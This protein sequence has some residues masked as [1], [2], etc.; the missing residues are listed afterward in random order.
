LLVPYLK[1]N[2]ALGI[3]ALKYFKIQ[4]KIE[5]FYNSRL[6]GRLTL[7][8]KN[9]LVDVGHNVLAAESILESLKGKKYILVY[10]SYKDKNYK[11]ILSIL[12]PVI[13]HVEL[14]DVYNIRIAESNYLQNT[15]ETLE[16]EYN[17]FKK[18]D[19]KKNYLVFGSFSVVE[20]FLKVYRG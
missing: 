1:E 5:D 10:N 14:I 15:L 13:L 3:S 11:E 8:E 18:I 12:K 2:L 4:Y 20:A 9:I 7:L 6:F 16:I 17:K 19:E